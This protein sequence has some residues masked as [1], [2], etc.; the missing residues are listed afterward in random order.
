MFG[1]LE[2]SVCGTALCV[3]YYIKEQ[4][5]YTVRKLPPGP[6]SLP[7]VGNAFNLDLKYPHRSLAELSKKYGDIFSVKLGTDRVV[8]LNSSEVIKEAYRGR[9]IASR[10]Q[11]YSLDLLMGDK[12][13]MAASQDHEQWSIHTKL[14][15][16]AIRLVNDTTMNGKIMEEIDYLVNQFNNKGKVAFDPKDDLMLASLNIICNLIYG[17]RYQKGD[18]ELQN[19]LHYSAEILK[20]ISPLHPVNSMPWLRHFPNKWFDAL[21]KAKNMRDRTLMKKYVEH[22]AKYEDGKINDM[23]DALLH[24]SKKAVSEKD[25][26]AINALSPEHI[27]INMW[28]M[29]FAGSDTVMNTLLWA[30]LYMV[31]FPKVQAK[32]QDQI[33]QEVGREQPVTM[34]HQKQLPYLNATICE[35]QRYSSQAVLGV[36]HCAATDTQVRGYTIPKGTQVLANLWAVHHD[37]DCWKDPEEFRPERFLDDDGN[38]RNMSEFP[39]FMPFSTGRRVCLGRSIAKKEM[40]MVLGN[41]MQKFIFDSPVG[42]EPDLE[43]ETLISLVP[44]PFNI[45]VYKRV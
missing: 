38:M 21:F 8:I 42:E 13:F 23:V 33:D 37:K 22:V 31:T 10:P 32:V 40:F 27:V 24:A 6:S 41:L 25:E 5:D 28:V 44:K 3:V 26:D 36:P 9:D 12:G 43:G 18:P 11:I 45:V 4:Y 34:D 17:Q 15:M 7:L 30:L 14:C 20:V 2:V 39:H 1:V 35:I 19:I 16:N 29:F